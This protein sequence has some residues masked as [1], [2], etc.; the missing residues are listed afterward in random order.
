MQN[1]GFVKVFAV[2]LT[3]V[4]MFYLSFSFVTRH[5]NS[6]AAE[7]AG[8]DPVKES[9]YLDSLSTQKVWLGY[10]LKQCREME[11]SLGLDLKGGMNVVLELNVADVIRSLSNNNQDENFNKALDLA[12]E[13]QATSQKDFIDLFAEEYKKLDNGAR[14]SAIFS[15]FEL[16]DKITPQSS[17]AQVIAVLKEELKSAID[18]SFNVLRNR[19]DRFGVVSPNIQR[20]ETAGRILVELPGVKEPERVRK[21]LQG[22][23]NL[24][25]W[26]TYNLPEIYQQLV[27][28]DNMLATI[29]KSDDTAAV[30]SDTTAI[31][32]TEEVVADNAAAETT[33]DADSLL[34]K[35]GEDKPEAQAAKSMEEFAKQHPL[36]AVLQINQYNG[37]LAPGPVVGIADKKDIAKINE[38][39]NMKQVKDILPRN[40][41][42][43]WGVKAIDEKEQY[44]YLYAIKMTNRDGTPALG[45]D[46]VTDANA[47]FVQQ[48]GRSEQQVS[49]TMNAE[50]AKAWARLTKE[51]IGKAVAIVLDDMVYSA[52]NVQVEITG[53]RSQ[54]TG[55]FTPEEAKDLA[56]VLKSGKM[57]ASV[58]IV[59]E[60][61][62]GP[63]LGQEAI[64]SGVISFVLALI[65]L[66]FY[67]CAFYGV[68]PG[69]IADGALV[70]NIFFTMGILASF[71]AV[72]TLPGIAGMVLT[73]GMAVDANVLIYERTKEELRAGKSLNKAIADGYSNAFSAIFDSNLTSIITG[74][75]LFYFGTGP[76]RGFATTMIIG[77]F[78]SF[79]TA[80]FLTRIVYEA[81][82][83]KDKLKNVTFT[84]SI[85]KDLLTNPKI[86]F[87]AARKVG[88]LIPAGIIVLGAI[89]MSTI[90]LNNGI[91]FT[92]GRNYVIR[93]AQDVKT[94]E[95]RNLLDAQLDGSVS[96]IQI[97][98]PDQV[99]V[100]TNYKIEDNDPAIDQEIENKLFEGV[101]SLL[102][103]GTTLA[104]FTDQYIQSSQKV[105]PS[106][107]DD[108]KNA[109]FLAVVF[110]MFC[111]AAYILLRFRDISFSVG[112]FASVA[113]TTLC[114]ISFYT[115]LWK[116]L[117]FSMEV[118]QTFIA[119]I[120]TIIGYSIN[121]TVVVFDRIR[122]TIGLYPK[123]DRYQV[124][125]DAL[126]STLSRTFNT[127][128]TTLVVVLCIF[129]LGGATI[130][131]FTFAILLGI[132]IGTYSTLFVATPIAYELQKKKINK[133]A[134]AE[135]GK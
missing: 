62:V 130:R 33:N 135:A 52:P 20:L 111:M 124:I 48:A 98:T 57:A 80:V 131:S 8:G 6:K 40:L 68:L 56:N 103:E 78:A 34:A 91:D 53:G 32:A 132:I 85:T 102:P 125:N 43:K 1:K 42:L 104:Q 23:A 73:L 54:I 13:N 37:Q 4:C 67:M 7:Y 119:A 95:V 5:Y 66:M 113:V 72:L 94:D 14:L 31:E 126:N 38:Y 29:L 121:D 46:V 47:D 71:Q 83:A 55:H 12:Y 74:V 122:E 75:V 109:A 76:I 86:N 81:L 79:L 134:A 10:T 17:D 64:N 90:G 118:D 61:V 88:Y 45:G 89:S 92:G 25:F 84:T 69:L 49:M 105:G 112:A 110:A 117:P 9:S 36:F 128:L 39:L 18:N 19:I 70:L 65:L 3:L 51:N 108:I 59:Q 21:L 97:G 93:F 58:H 123:R 50:G 115:L 24:E 16:K 26:E 30:G 41:S 127:S 77:L 99:R 28:A 114:I 15:T 101:K 22:S 44:F 106:M 27:A 116:V 133:K 82:L 11:I 100:S 120:L 96:V 2:L 60:D 63:S 35:I 87:L 107:A 129:I